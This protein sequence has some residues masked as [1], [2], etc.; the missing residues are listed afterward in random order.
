MQDYGYNDVGYHESKPSPANPGGLP[1]T[2]AV[3]G[4]PQTPFLDQL[5]SESM[6]LE[7]YYVQPLCSPTRATIMV[8]PVSRCVHGELAPLTSHCWRANG[9]CAAC[10]LR[11]AVLPAILALG[12]T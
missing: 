4:A 5:A 2:S 10:T 12:P 7:M 1:T 6:R 9:A 8:T 3:A 11:L